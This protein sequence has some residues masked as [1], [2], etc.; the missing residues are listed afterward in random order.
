MWLRI[1]VFTLA[2]VCVTAQIDIPES[3][4]TVVIEQGTVQGSVSFNG[5]F[6]F[7]GIPYADA[8]SGTNRFKVR[9]TN[10]K[11]NIKYMYKC[12]FSFI[13]YRFSG[14]K[15][16]SVIFRHICGQQKRREMREGIRSGL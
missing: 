5:N 9:L 16:S 14:T 7:Y 6:E 10:K 4:P 8:T 1:G 13:F 2:V 15:S 3:D 11:L 12:E